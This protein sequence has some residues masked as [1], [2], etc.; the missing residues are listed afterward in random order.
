ML[1]MTSS[2][3]F[4]YPVELCRELFWLESPSLTASPSEW[5]ASSTWTGIPLE[6]S[7]PPFFLPSDTMGL[8]QAAVRE[9][10]PDTAQT[11]PMPGSVEQ[12][13]EAGHTAWMHSHAFQMPWC[14]QCN[15]HRPP[16]TLHCAICNICV[17]EFD[18]HSRWVNNCIG[19]RNFRL[20][21]LL[22]VSLCL[23]LVAL[24]VTCVI[25]VVRTTDMSLS[26]DKIVAIIVTVLATGAL[27][28]VI[29][30]LLVQA[31][32]VSTARRLYEVQVSRAEFL[33]QD[34]PL[35]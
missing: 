8:L 30:E 35:G 5:S 4:A 27:L 21:L 34:T 32:A 9:G 2:T 31:V 6:I 13:P 17:E 22:L 15:F 14:H 19:H 28:P 25:F 1:V 10:P 7:S 20:F 18:H 23:Y 24:V 29:F 26:L 33:C 12:D 16:R 11:L 3:F